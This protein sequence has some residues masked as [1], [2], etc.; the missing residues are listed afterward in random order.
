MSFFLKVKGNLRPVFDRFVQ[1][2]AVYRT[3]PKVAIKPGSI[4]HSDNALITKQL[5]EFCATLQ[6]LTSK[7]ILKY[8]TYYLYYVQYINNG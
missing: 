4:F 6:V 1:Q 5:E 2:V 3:V 8:R 7:S